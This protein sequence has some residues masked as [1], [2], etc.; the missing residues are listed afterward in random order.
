MHATSL[1]SCLSLCTL[2]TVAH[3]V[4][5]SMGLP[6]ARI[7]EWVAISF[8]K[9]SSRWMQMSFSFPKDKQLSTNIILLNEGF[10]LRNTHPVRLY[11]G[12]Y[13]LVVLKSYPYFT[14][15]KARLVDLS[16]RECGWNMGLRVTSSVSADC[17]LMN[18]V[19][20]DQSSVLFVSDSSYISWEDFMSLFSRI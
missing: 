20:L 4:S 18:S 2:W 11:A 8:S 19:T 10:F 16:S 12:Y 13:P 14:P 5:L 3:Q 1:Q 9:I 15:R 6:L 7:L 17:P